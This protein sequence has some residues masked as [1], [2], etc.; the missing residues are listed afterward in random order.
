MTSGMPVRTEDLCITRRANIVAVSQYNDIQKTHHA[1]FTYNSITTP[2]KIP[3]SIIKLPVLQLIKPC[4]VSV[5]YKRPFTD[6][7]L[8]P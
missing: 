8:L 6:T 1:D 7:F 2:G 3:F 4:C 5:F